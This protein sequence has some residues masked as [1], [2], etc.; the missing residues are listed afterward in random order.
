[1][2]AENARRQGGAAATGAT[3]LARA[4][5]VVS[6]VTLVS[7]FGGLL[8]EVLVVRLFKATALGSAFSAGFAIPNMFRRLFGEGALSAAFIPEYT[9]AIK[10][11]PELADRFASLTVGLLALVTGVLT[12][13]IELALLAILLIAPGG[14]ARVLSLQLI[15]LMLPF[16]PLV[17]IAAILG[18]MLQV[19]GKFGPAAS[20]PLTLNGFIIAVAGVYLAMGRAGDRTAA[21]AIGIATVLSGLTQVIWF[22]RLLKPHIRWRRDTQLAWG[23]TRTML[24][25]FVPVMIGLGTLQ[26]ASLVDL[27]V[28]MWP[29]WV[30]PTVLGR[31]YPLDEASGIILTAAQR[32]YQFPLGVFGIA[33][34]TAVFPMLSRH[35]DEPGQFVETLRRGVRLSLYIGLPASAGLALVRDP[36][37][38]VTYSGGG[39]FNSAAVARSAAV[40]LGYG[41]AVWA[42]SLNHVFTRAFYARGD[43]RTPMKVAVGMV[44]LNLALNLI[45]IW[46]LREAGLAW[47][48]SIAAMIQC[49]TLGALVHRKLGVAV[50]DAPTVKGVVRIVVAVALMAIAVAGV[51]WAWPAAATWPGHLART[52]GLC[53]VGAAAYLAGSKVLRT[54][55]LGWLLH[56]ERGPRP[57]DGDE[58]AAAMGE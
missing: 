21:Y 30:G 16:M 49:V 19:H 23:I 56:R 57:G 11:D 13:L 46:W 33:V 43:T 35:A 1:M 9:R 44:L 8:R 51:M 6:G 47:A 20:G 5:R 55:E 40:L 12:L 18:G 52:A 2:D 36:L 31:A 45:L 3:G 50:L 7:R 24:R 48:T 41:P 42:Y 53:M 26:I 14:A 58:I 22:V 15:M 37:M 25:R 28:A 29:N 32:L 4:V 17:C 54:P 34:A 38:A 27:A 39:G 10:H